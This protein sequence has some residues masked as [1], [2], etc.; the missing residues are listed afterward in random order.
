[1][2]SMAK[3]PR[4]IQHPLAIRGMPRFA[5]P[6]PPDGQISETAVQSLLQKYF[7][8]HLSQI[9]SLSGAVSCPLGGAYRDRHGRWVRDAVDADALLTNGA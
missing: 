7:C 5:R 2:R 8:F 6:S 9:I 3:P 1:M 4:L